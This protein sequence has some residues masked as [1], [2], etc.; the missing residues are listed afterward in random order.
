MKK[1][2]ALIIGCLICCVVYAKDCAGIYK[3]AYGACEADPNLAMMDNYQ[4][5][6]RRKALMAVDKCQSEYPQ[7]KSTSIIAT[8]KYCTSIYKRAYGICE[9]DPNLAMMDNYQR[10]CR[11]KALMA[12]DKCQRKFS[13]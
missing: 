6:C 3:E 4:L 5:F 12:V 1:I 10:F 8:T 2:I 11:M 13:N 7:K 9:A